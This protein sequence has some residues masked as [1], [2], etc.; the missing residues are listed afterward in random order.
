MHF[1][2]SLYFLLLFFSLG[3]PLFLTCLHIFHLLVSCLH[4]IYLAHQCVLAIEFVRMSSLSYCWKRKSQIPSICF[5]SCNG[6]LTSLVGCHQ[7]FWFFAFMVLN[8]FNSFSVILEG[9]QEK[10]EI[11]A[12]VGSK[13]FK[14]KLV[15]ILFLELCSTA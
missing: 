11:N 7:L 14:L 9:F 10:F 1:L 2:C 12:F 5:L 15:R 6:S 3:L 13:M 4:V 8:I